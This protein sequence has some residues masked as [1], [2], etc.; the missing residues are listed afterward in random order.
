MNIFIYKAAMIFIPGILARI[1]LDR[2]LF[3]KYKDKFHFV[4]HS[5]LLGIASYCILAFLQGLLAFFQTG[6]F[7]VNISFFN[8]SIED[9]DL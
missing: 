9:R 1:M 3:Y 5:F 8:K 4:L 6:C 2:L 7:S